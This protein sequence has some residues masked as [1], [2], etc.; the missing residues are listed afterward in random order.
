M[1][2]KNGLGSPIQLQVTLTTCFPRFFS[3]ARKL[4]NHC[5]HSLLGSLLPLFL[6]ESVLSQRKREAHFT[7]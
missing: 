2:K 5:G 6:L 3:S 1:K 4:K 7:R